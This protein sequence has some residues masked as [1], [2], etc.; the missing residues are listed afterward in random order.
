[1]AIDYICDM[2]G[3]RLGANY[4]ERFIVKTETY[5]AA[6]PMELSDDDLDQEGELAK[7]IEELKSADPDE[8]EDQ[9]YRSFRFD[10]CAA[11]HRV[12]LKHPLGQLPQST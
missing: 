5:A 4:A 10:L 8:V 3:A 2:C 6:A 12:F 1:M 9:I 7:V 11:C